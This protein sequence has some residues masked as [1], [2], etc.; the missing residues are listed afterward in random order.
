MFFRDAKLELVVGHYQVSAQQ[1]PL[2]KVYRNAQNFDSTRVLLNL[3]I[4]FEYDVWRQN[5]TVRKQN[6]GANRVRSLDNELFT[7]C[8][9]HQRC[10]HSLLEDER[11]I[12]HILRNDQQMVLLQTFMV[13]VIC[14]AYCLLTI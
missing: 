10:R 13:S 9:H 6:E 14:R 8:V 4:R 7:D 2:K 1:R 12:D 5:E 11:L 3:L